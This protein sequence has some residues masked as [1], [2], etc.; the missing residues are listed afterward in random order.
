MNLFLITAVAYSASI[1]GYSLYQMK[2]KAAP[3]QAIAAIFVYLIIP[4]AL[5]YFA[6]VN[7]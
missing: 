4:F 5:F 3:G 1:I 7:A 6:G 2:E